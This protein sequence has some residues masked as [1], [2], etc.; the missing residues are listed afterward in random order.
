MKMLILRAVK[1][2]TIELL[3]K[4]LFKIEVDKKPRNNLQPIIPPI[5][6]MRKTLSSK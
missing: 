5:V 6:Q 3:L 4:M 1:I 2:I